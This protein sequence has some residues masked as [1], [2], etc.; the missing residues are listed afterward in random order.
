MQQ[1][2]KRVCKEREKNHLRWH[3]LEKKTT[4]TPS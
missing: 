1:D 3:C 4:P 2:D